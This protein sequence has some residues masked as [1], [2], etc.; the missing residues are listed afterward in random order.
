MRGIPALKTPLPMIPGADI[1]GEIVALGDAVR[2]RAS[3]SASGWRCSPVATRWNDGRDPARRAV[4]TDRRR[5]ALTAAGAGRGR[6]SIR[7]PACRPPMPPRYRMLHARGRLQAGETG[8]DPRRQRR[9]RHL[10]RPACQGRRAEVVAVTV[11]GRKAAKLKALGADHVIDSSHRH[12]VDFVVDTYGKPRTRGVGGGVDVCVNYYGRRHLGRVLPRGAARRADPDLRRHRRLRSEDRHPLH[13]VVRAHHHRLERLARRGPPEAA[14]PDRRRRAGAGDRPGGRHGRDA[15]RRC[16]TCTSAGCSARS[17]LG[18]VRDHEVTKSRQVFRR[19][20]A[21]RQ[22]RADRA[23]GFQPRRARPPMPRWMPNATRWRA[24]WWRGGYRPG[25]RDRPDWRSTAA[26]CWLRISG[27]CGPGWWRCRS[28]TSWAEVIAHIAADA[29]LRRCS[30]MPRGA[31]LVPGGRRRS[32]WTG[33]T[34][35]ELLRPRA[36]RDDRAGGRAAWR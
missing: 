31:D 28:A 32:R 8:A 23:G 11:R 25:D 16:A 4:R 13:L 10:L 36:V 21:A 22:D 33:R 24:G 14:G 27:S 6:R 3:P 18:S 12:Y 2:R 5:P 29:R 15:A 30:T 17:C 9:R 7:R 34:I 19:R 26:S 1:T 35:A 20:R